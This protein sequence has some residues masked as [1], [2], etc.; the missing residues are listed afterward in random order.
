MVA[1]KKETAAETLSEVRSELKSL[2]SELQEKK[3]Q[4]RDAEGNEI[5]TQTA[6]K[7]YV[8]KLRGKSTQYK[9]KRQEQQDM[10]A[11]IGTLTRTVEILRQQAEPYRGGVR[12]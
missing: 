1:R 10:R 11:E 3:S 9:K 4:M 12:K 2:E 5:I 7:N 8:N 6:F